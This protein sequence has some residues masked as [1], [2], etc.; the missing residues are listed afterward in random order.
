MERRD[1]R[2]PTGNGRSAPNGRSGFHLNEHQTSM[3]RDEGLLGDD[4]S[5]EDIAKRDR[6]MS[7]WKAGADTLRRSGAR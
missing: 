5:K 4:L 1:Q 7:K 6:I 3:L 2:P